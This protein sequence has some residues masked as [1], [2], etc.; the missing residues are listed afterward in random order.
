MAYTSEPAFPEPAVRER[1]PE[2]A[3]LGIPSLSVPTPH[4]AG[5]VAVPEI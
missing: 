5:K 1:F 2:C 4:V 3:A